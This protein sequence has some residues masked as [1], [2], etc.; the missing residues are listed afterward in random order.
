MSDWGHGRRHHGYGRH[1]PPWWPED[2]SWPPADAEGP[3]QWHDRRGAFMWRMGC[4][5]IV[6]VVVLVLIVGALASLIG[7]ALTGGQSGIGTVLVGLLVIVLLVGL[8]RA[9]P[10]GG[11][12]RRGADRGLGPG[13]IR[14]LQHPRG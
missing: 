13:R 12:T 5:F 14:R 2:E 4:F 3:E 10:P 11:G 6:M 9:R 1:R 7:G 8:A